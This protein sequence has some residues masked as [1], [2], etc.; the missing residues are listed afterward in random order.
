M[1]QKIIR[2]G[3]S[4]AVTLPSAFVKAQKIKAGQVV[5]VD[6]DQDLDLVQVRT[7]KHAPSGLT[8]EFKQWLDKTVIQHA[9]GIKKL[10]QK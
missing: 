2:A 1:E 4:L 7:K 10:A 3:N 6:A 5:Y 9:E 8:P